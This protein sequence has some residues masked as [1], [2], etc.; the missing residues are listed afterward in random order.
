MGFSVA[1][2]DSA[3]LRHGSFLFRNYDK[4]NNYVF[5]KQTMLCNLIVSKYWV[6]LYYLFEDWSRVTNINNRIKVYE[7][8]R[9]GFILNQIAGHSL[10]PFIILDIQRRF[11]QAVYDF[12]Y[13]NFTV[14]LLNLLFLFFILFLLWFLIYLFTLF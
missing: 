5:Y 3:F 4:G 1:N 2:L 12:P 14:R 13:A 11:L 9:I 8:R 6:F 10:S 7:L